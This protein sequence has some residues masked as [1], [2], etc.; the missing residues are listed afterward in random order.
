MNYRKRRKPA[1][2][3]PFLHR[4]CRLRPPL[5]VSGAGALFCSTFSLV[6][7][8]D[9]QNFSVPKAAEY[10]VFILAALFLTLTTW[11]LISLCRKKSPMQVVSDAAHAHHLPARLWDDPTF[12]AIFLSFGSLIINGLLAL[13]KAIAGWWLSS[14]WLIVLAVYYLV[15]SLSRALILQNSRR[16]A[17]KSQAGGCLKQA[18]KSYRLCGLLLLLLALTLQGVVLLII[19]DD[20]GFSYQGNLIYLVALVDFFGLSSAVAYF[21]RNRKGHSPAI[22]SIKCLNFA[23]SLVSMLSLQTAMFASFGTD[24]AAATQRMMNTVTGTAV[25]A[26]LALLGIAMAAKA[27]R[28]LRQQ[29]V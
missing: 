28:K 23:S 25:C 20:K 1:Q 3:I 2:N 24:M 10:V 11:S 18:W 13:S 14:R 22:L 26:I 15:L 21:I 6:L 4:L 16:I 8:S 7:V 27:A 19:R 12:R 29:Q 5:L 9:H 17:Q